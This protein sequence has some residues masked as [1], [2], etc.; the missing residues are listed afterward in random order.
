M[1]MELE[2]KIREALKDIDSFKTP[3]C[4]D[5]NII[6][7]YA[8]N[9]LAEPQQQAA[10]AHLHTCLYC[11]KQLNDITELLYYEKKQ[12]PL[13]SKLASQLRAILPEPEN[14]Q[15]HCNRPT[16][17]IQRL[18]DLFTFSSQQWRFSAIGLAT[19]WMVF[20]ISIVVM[21]QG[22]MPPGAPRLN[23]DSFVKVQALS[24]SGAILREQQGWLS[25]QTD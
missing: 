5:I 11:L 17:I 7:R 6:G 4:L 2:G 22:N 3:D 19:A 21:R 16:P 18:K 24:D 15:P 20:L 10:E 23:P 12:V 25:D 8:E 9:K 13:S 1:N 14:T